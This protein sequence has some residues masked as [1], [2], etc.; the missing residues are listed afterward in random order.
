MPAVARS[1]SVY[2]VFFCFFLCIVYVSI[3]ESEHQLIDCLLP[4]IYPIF[5]RTTPHI[6]TLRH[7]TNEYT[8][9]LY[10]HVYASLRRL[11][12]SK[13]NSMFGE[14]FAFTDA[15]VKIW[16]NKQ[17][18]QILIGN[19]ALSIALHTVQGHALQDESENSTHQG[20]T[21]S[22]VAK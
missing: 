13:D 12:L 21:E 15:V 19:P 22:G 8:L 16:T 14:Y 7:K 5:I 20:N 9:A 17:S 18:S 3:F 10:G 4:C 2:R 1:V 6:R 11:F